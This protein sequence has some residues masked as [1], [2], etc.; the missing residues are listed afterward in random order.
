MDLIEQI[1]AAGVVGAGGAGFP[2]YAK[3]GSPADY[4]LMNAAECAPLLRVDQQ[5]RSLRVSIWLQRLQ[6]LKRLLSE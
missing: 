5:T 4:L 6:E 1:K 3:F 2:T